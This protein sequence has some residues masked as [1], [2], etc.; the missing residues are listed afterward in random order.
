VLK[1]QIGNWLLA[2][3]LKGGYDH[4]NAVRDIGL[5]DGSVL[6]AR[7]SPEIYYLGGRLRAAYE[8][9]RDGWYVK[10]YVDLDVN[11]ANQPGYKESG[12][13]L[14]NLSVSHGDQ[15]S[16]MLSPS[17]EVGGRYDLSNGTTVRPFASVGVSFLANGNW[18]SKLRLSEM[19]GSLPAFTVST[20]MP[21]VY[22]NLTAGVELL[23]SRR[24]EL[25]AEYGLHAATH[26]VD[27]SATLR[28]AYH[29]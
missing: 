15:V 13:G 5:P 23:G 2:A 17:I 20:D 21:K 12:A 26:Y 7:S 4:L 1:H 27:Q 14:L 6:Q 22:G 29:F 18:A 19:P 9:P 24:Y 25:K 10:P 28:L 11:Y 16:A 8:I 3:A